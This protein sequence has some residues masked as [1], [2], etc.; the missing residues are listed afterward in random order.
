MDHREQLVPQLN[1]GLAGLGGARQIVTD[2]QDDGHD[3]QDG[4]PGQ[5]PAEMPGALADRKYR[6]HTQC[7][8]PRAPVPHR[9]G[10]EQS[11]PD[12]HAG[13]RQT[14]FLGFNSS[15]QDKICNGQRERDL[16]KDCQVRRP[17]ICSTRG[18]AVQCKL[19]KPHDP[20][21]AREHLPQ[22]G[23]SLPYPQTSDNPQ[24]ARDLPPV[25]NVI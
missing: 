6:Q 8:R 19:R 4:C 12:R 24:E 20:V 9:K 10:Q 3:Y 5:H 15:G 11:A 16:E 14:N 17:E 2:N 1:P 21:P 7:R 22:A 13:K 18:P 23:A 25:P